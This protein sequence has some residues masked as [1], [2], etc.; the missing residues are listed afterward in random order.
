MK[1]LYIILIL[2]LN[3]SCS[4]I[5]IKQNLFQKKN[6]LSYISN[7]IKLNLEYK[8]NNSIYF[9]LAKSNNLKKY[10]IYLRWDSKS[11]NDKL[12]NGI[13]TTIKFIIDNDKIL[14]LHPNKTPSIVKDDVSCSNRYIEEIIV[15]LSAEDFISIAYANTVAVEIINNK[16]VMIG[17]LTEKKE[18]LDFK[19]FLKYSN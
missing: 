6:E 2:L 8:N 12:F 17:L 10:H 18:L 9:I 14:S 16:K 13:N 15:T 1:I 19:E 3:N 5:S 11:K 7:P 4:K